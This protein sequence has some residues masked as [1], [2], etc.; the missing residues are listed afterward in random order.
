MQTSEG[1]KILA[2]FGTYGKGEF[3]NNIFPDKETVTQSN[4]FAR[5]KTGYVIKR[6][7]NILCNQKMR[8]RKN[9]IKIVEYDW[10]N[11]ITGLFFQGL[12]TDPD[13]LPSY[14][15]SGKEDVLEQYEK[16]T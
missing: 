11:E 8:K 7:M 6:K 10:R 4:R 2:P 16:K 1:K 15:V 3:L 13:R 12:F 14:M 5:Q 9:V